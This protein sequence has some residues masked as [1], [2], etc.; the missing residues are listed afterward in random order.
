VKELKNWSNLS[1]FGTAVTTKHK[2]DKNQAA[3]LAK[4]PGFR[5]DTN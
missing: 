2:L 1:D 3:T 4:T 5:M